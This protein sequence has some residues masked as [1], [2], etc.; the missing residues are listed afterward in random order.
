[1]RLGAA[2]GCFG[3]QNATYM[4]KIDILARGLATLAKGPDEILRVQLRDRAGRM[5]DDVDYKI[6]TIG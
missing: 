2:P 5:D 1:M 6:K 4:H 3:R